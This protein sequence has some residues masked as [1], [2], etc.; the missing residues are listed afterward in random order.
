M[1]ALRGVDL[2][3]V[4]GEFLAVMG[5]VGAGKSTLCLAL[6]GAIP[7]AVDGEFSGRV[8]VYGQDTQTVSMG[9]LVA[10]C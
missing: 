2:E 5:P 10:Q 4:H 7:H 1:P 6:N 3:A 9:Q 8:T